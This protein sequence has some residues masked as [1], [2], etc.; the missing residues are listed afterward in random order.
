MQ[1]EQFL[2]FGALAL[3]LIWK[4]RNQVIHKNLKPSQEDLSRKLQKKFL[5]HWCLTACLVTPTLGL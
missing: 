2:L 4:A 3:D 1:K 5:E